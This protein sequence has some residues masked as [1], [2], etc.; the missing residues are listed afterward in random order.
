MQSYTFK[1]VWAPFNSITLQLEQN[2][3]FKT[4]REHI[5]QKITRFFNIETNSYDIVKACQKE[6]E[7]GNYIDESDDTLININDTRGF[8]IRLKPNQERICVECEICYV[9]NLVR[10]ENL[11]NC[12]HH[13]FCARC[14][15]RW[16]NTC[17][18]NRNEFTCPICRSA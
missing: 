18:Q 7:L 14:L 16:R 8:Y 10:S 9:S 2:I 1:Q 15:N 17:E 13:N 6:R 3:T 4:I 5:D 12:T 11:W